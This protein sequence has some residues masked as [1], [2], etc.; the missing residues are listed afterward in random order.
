MEHLTRSVSIRFMLPLLLLCLM[1]HHSICQEVQPKSSTSP[2]LIPGDTNDDMD[3]PSELSLDAARKSVDAGKTLAWQVIEYSAKSARVTSRVAAMAAMGTM[4]NDPRVEKLVL[5][6]CE[7]TDREV[8]AAAVIA[9]GNTRDRTLIPRLRQA[10]D[11]SAPEVS[12][13]AAVALWIQGDRSGENVLYGVLK[14]EKKSGP[15]AVEKAKR[16]MQNPSTLAR[17]GAEQGAYA[18]LGPL[19][20]GLDVAKAL[21]KSS[22]SNPARVLAANLLVQSPT[23]NTK[24]QLI[25]AL[26]DHDPFVR[27]AAARSLNAFHGDDVN[28]ALITAFGD[29]KPAVRAMAAASYLLVNTPSRRSTVPRLHRRSRSSTPKQAPAQKP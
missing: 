25:A 8:R 22:N 19:G 11:D 2:E 18:L 20:I 12:F 14:G 26:L 4:G 28:Q 3:D 5:T 15:G 21:R 17:L 29:S 7:D 16:D 6:A 24:E 23:Q 9:M 27:S 10:L 13:N 1:P